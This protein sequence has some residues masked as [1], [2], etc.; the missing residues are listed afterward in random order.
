M[1]AF[2]RGELPPSFDAQ[3]FALDAGEISEVVSTDF[4]FHLFRVNSRTA[5]EP[6]SIDQVREA[7]QV[8]L[9]REKSEEAMKRYVAKLESRYPLTVH[10]Q[11]LSFAPA[12]SFAGEDDDVMEKSR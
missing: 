11:N 9:L 10:Q 4:G 2:A 5:E 8:E 6:L 12:R 3:V 1:G 7:V